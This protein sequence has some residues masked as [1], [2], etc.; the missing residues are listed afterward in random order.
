MVPDENI[1]NYVVDLRE[2]LLLP[3]TGMDY[4]GTGPNDN[5]SR[6]AAYW[7]GKRDSGFNEAGDVIET[8]EHAGDFKEP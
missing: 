6:C 5:R 3:E 2:Q 8:P 1:G 7:E 4:F